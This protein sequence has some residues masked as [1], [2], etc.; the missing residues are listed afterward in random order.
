MEELTKASG[1]ETPATRQANSEAVGPQFCGS[2]ISEAYLGY[3]LDPMNYSSKMQFM[4]ISEGVFT[5]KNR[6][7]QFDI[8]NSDATARIVRI[9]GFIS[10]TGGFANYNVAAGAADFA[11][12]TDQFG[13]NVKK[14]QGFG[15]FSIGMPMIITQIRVISDSATQL[16]QTFGYNVINPDA[17][18]TP[19]PINVA[20]TEAKSDQ[21][22]NLVVIYGSWIINTNHFLDYNALGLAANAHSL[23]LEV[24]GVRNVGDFVQL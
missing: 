24:S 15:Q 23:I 11:T 7:A 19:T 17:T 4:K 12:C 6:Y 14:L 16:A 22:T 13:T 2:N 5:S 9:G 1:C 20:A 8:T 21:R 3:A 18:I 10:L